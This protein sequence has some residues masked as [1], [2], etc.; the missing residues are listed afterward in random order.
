MI[1]FIFKSS[2]FKHFI[3]LGFHSLL[4]FRN[5]FIFSLDKKMI[6]VYTIFRPTVDIKR[7]EAVIEDGKQKRVRNLIILRQ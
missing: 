5:F 7:K 6:L 4:S 3:F 2:V 1:F